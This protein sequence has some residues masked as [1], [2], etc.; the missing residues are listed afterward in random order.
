M[1]RGPFPP[2]KITY[3]NP[4]A[5]FLQ[6]RGQLLYQIHLDV[7]VDRQFRILVRRVNRSA[8]VKVDIR[9][10]FKQQTADQGRSVPF[11]APLL[12]Q[13]VFIKSIPSVLN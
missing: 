13:F 1:Q 7:E 8:Y 6:A 4:L 9:C 11:G 2:L 3:L 5:H 12:V 10:F